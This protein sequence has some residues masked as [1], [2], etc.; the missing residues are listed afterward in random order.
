M[1]KNLLRSFVVLL[2]IAASTSCAWAK[3]CPAPTSVTDNT[4]R[5]QPQRFSSTVNLADLIE[6][7]T[8]LQGFSINFELTS[9]MD[10]QRL[11]INAG[12]CYL[13]TGIVPTDDMNFTVS[14]E[15]SMSYTDTCG[16]ASQA[17]P[18]KPGK[19]FFRGAGIEYRIGNPVAFRVAAGVLHRH[20]Y[21]RRL[22]GNLCRGRGCV[23]RQHHPRRPHR[24][25]PDA[26]RGLDQR[27]L[28]RLSH[29]EQRR[30]DRYPHH[31]RC[32]RCHG[33]L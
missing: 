23:R 8:L 7:D 27:H 29:R 24:R 9:G 4:V 26:P 25:H 10:L 31:P 30:D 15:S 16:I 18:D 21:R 32:R 28:H 5:T 14:N 6:G 13:N 22:G 12:R 19:N 3:V 11:T 1:T 17:I 33:Q 2:A 20:R